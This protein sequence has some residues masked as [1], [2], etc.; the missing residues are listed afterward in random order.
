MIKDLNTIIRA[1]YLY[2]NE[3]SHD[4]VYNV[5]EGSIQTIDGNRYEVVGEWGPRNGVLKETVKYSGYDINLADEAYSDLIASKLKKGYQKVD[6][7][8]SANWTSLTSKSKAKS[9]NKPEPKEK[10]KPNYDEF[11]VPDRRLDFDDI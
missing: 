1:E 3:G 8:V 4:K 7:S 9:I 6:S 5:V 2:C 10:I 11:G